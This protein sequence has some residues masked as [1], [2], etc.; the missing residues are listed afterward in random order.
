MKRS[1]LLQGFDSACEYA[2]LSRVSS[3]LTGGRLPRG[4]LLGWCI[5]SIVFE[6]LY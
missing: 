2:E 6:L 3:R 1:T 5:H 4:S